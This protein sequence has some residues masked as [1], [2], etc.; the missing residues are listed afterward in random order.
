MKILRIC[1]KDLMI[2]WRSL[3]NLPSMFFFSLLVIV[4]FN[5]GFSL[6]GSRFEAVGPG[7]LW[8]AFVFAGVLSFGHS[9]AVEKDSD[10]MQGLRLAPV[11][12]GSIFFGKMLANLI[13]MLAVEALVLPLCMVLFN[14]ALGGVFWRLTF[15]ILV[16]T[17]GFTAVGTLFGAMAARTRRGDVLLPVLLFGTSMPLM[18]S[19]VKTTAAALTTDPALDRAAGAWLTMAVVFDVV[20]MTAAWLTFEYIIEE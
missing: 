15:V 7:V 5:F 17:V 9:F 20:F 8:V 13:T 3:D 4:I 10:C 19:A 11:D 1:L 18:I 14:A 6:S 12:P 16:H 2:E